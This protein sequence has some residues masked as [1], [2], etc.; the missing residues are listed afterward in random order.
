MVDKLVL[1]FWEPFLRLVKVDN[2]CPVRILYGMP[3]DGGPMMHDCIFD[4][5]NVLVYGNEG[6]GKTVFLNTLVKTASYA[7]T[8]DDVRLVLVD[9]KS[10]GFNPYKNSELLLCPVIDGASGLIS[11]LEPLI[12][13]LNKRKELIGNTSFEVYREQRDKQVPYVLVVVDDYADIASKETNQTVLSLLREWH[14]YG[15]HV[16]LATQSI[17]DLVADME[18]FKSFK[19]VICQRNTEQEKTKQLIGD[20]YELRGGGDSLALIN[21]K[22]TRI[23]NLYSQSQGNLTAKIDDPVT[24]DEM[25]IF[26]LLAK[27]NEEVLVPIDENNE[28]I[29]C[30]KVVTIFNPRNSV[31]ADIFDK[32]RKAK[33]KF[34]AL[35]TSIKGRRLNL[36][37]ENNNN[38]YS[39]R[40]LE[41]LFAQN[42]GNE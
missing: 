4:A 24:S 10:D 15:I 35:L 40:I 27:Y 6:S 1:D 21:G 31:K 16:I 30:D 23:Q 26:E 8:V 32:H 38:C 34:W 13:E 37:L 39:R 9:P 7:N 3:Y 28:I 14:R 33:M 22:L 12:E 36:R 29:V 20:Y 17:G 18:F 2:R 5:Q 25:W 11:K 19:T 41:R 42:H